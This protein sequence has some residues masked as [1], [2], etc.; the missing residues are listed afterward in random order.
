MILFQSYSLAGR[1]LVPPHPGA[2]SALGLLLADARRDYSQ[3]LLGRRLPNAAAFRTVFARLHEKGIGELGREGFSRK[4]IRIAD[5]LDVRYA[6]QSFELTVPYGRGWESGFHDAHSRRYGYQNPGKP[7]E[8]V[9]ARTTLVG[10]T[11]APDLPVSRRRRPEAVP[12]ETARVWCD[13]RWRRTPVFDRARLGYGARIPGP[14][15]IGEYSSTT[16]VPPRYRASLDRHGNLILERGA[17][18]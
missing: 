11:R 10:P 18:R 15:V 14:A 5:A 13:G 6:G 16:W 1:V 3:S 8:V 4:D 12:R 9:A 2:L 17:G 7:L